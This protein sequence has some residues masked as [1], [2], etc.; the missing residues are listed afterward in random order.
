MSKSIKF[1]IIL[2][3]IETTHYQN[4]KKDITTGLF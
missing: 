4:M 2:I 1:I 3:Y